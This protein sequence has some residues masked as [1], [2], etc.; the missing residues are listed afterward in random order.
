MT[1]PRDTV[2][3]PSQPNTPLPQVLPA[4]LV[5]GHHPL[6]SACQ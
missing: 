1:R 3:L 6:P 5:V 4:P 2:P